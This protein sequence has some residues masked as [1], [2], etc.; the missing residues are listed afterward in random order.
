VR[1]GEIRIE[2]HQ[3][4]DESVVRDE[5]TLKTGDLYSDS[6][7]QKSQRQVSDLGLFRSV[8]IVGL[9]SEDVSRGPGKVTRPIS[10]KLEERP[11]H[12]VRFGL[13][14]GTEDKLR[15]QGGWLHR[16][17]FGRAD[18][19]D[20]RAK[21]STLTRE[22]Q[23]TLREP[24]LP[25]PRTT[26]W[27]DSRVRDDTL[28]AYD[29]L[30]FLNRVAVERPLRLG[31]SGLVGYNA[32][33]INVRKVTEEQATGLTHPTSDYVLGYLEL[34]LR[35][36]TADSLVEPT[37]G[38]WLETNLEVASRYV[39]SQKNYVRW[40][41]DGRGFLPLGPTVLAGRVLLGSLTGI[42]KTN[43]SELPVTKL[44]Y[45]GGSGISRGYDY[46][47]LGNDHAPGRAVGGESLL[48]GSLELRFPLWGELHGV[49]FGDT[50]Q[51]GTGPRDWQPRKLRYSVGGGLRYATP[52]GPIRFDVATP[53]DEPSGVS[54]LRFWFAIGQAF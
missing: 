18:T 21:Y 42:N 15:V 10:V 49:A 28:P 17:I 7:L 35:R 46:Q 29:D 34:G 2:G 20:I 27:L 39:G 6:E 43:Q 25:D 33:A 12:S 50:G 41:L 1:I 23:A 22:F 53:L 30:G 8:L 14:Y 32:E 44:F 47:H 24:H 26:L 19:L 37:R 54:N 13:G 48:S 36:I 31:W 9:P 38:T 40:T 4:V 3:T 45:S 52:L 51:L 5:L 11:L 16:N